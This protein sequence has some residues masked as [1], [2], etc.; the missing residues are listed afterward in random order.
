M[1]LELEPGKPASRRRLETQVLHFDVDTWQAYNY[2]W[3]DEQTDAVLADDMAATGRFRSATRQLPAAAAADLAPRQPDRV[4]PLP[5]D[6]GRHRSSASGR[7]SSTASTITAGRLPISSRRSTT[8]ACSPSRCPTSATPGPIRTTQSA[9]L[10]AA[11]PGL[12]A[13]QLRPLPSPRRRRLVVL[14]RA[15]C[16][17]TLAKTSLLGTR[18]TQGTF[19]IL[20]AEIVAPGDPYRSVLYYRMASSATAACRSSA[21]RSIDPHGH[22]ADPRLDRVAA[23]GRRT[24]RHATQPAR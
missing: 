12:P 17:C 13:R 19:G 24:T 18:P 9:D 2:I 21:R 8:S 7:R 3:N 10:E 15:V 20:G 5:H 11:G 22:A 14:R 4:P 1:S 16:T 23:A 6:A